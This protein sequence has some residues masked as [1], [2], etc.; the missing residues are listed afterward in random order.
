MA[1][2]FITPPMTFGDPSTALTG[3][4]RPAVIDNGAGF[5]VWYMK[6]GTMYHSTADAS[7]AINGGGAVAVTLTGGASWVSSAT[8]G[9]GDCPFVIKADDGKFY[10]WVADYAGTAIELYVATEAAG[11]WAYIR[12]VF[13][14]SSTVGDWDYGK[15]DEPMVIFDGAGY[16]LFY[17]GSNLDLSFTY[18]IGLANGNTAAI[19]T[20][21]TANP[22]NPVLIPTG[23]TFYDYRVFQPYVVK[24]GGQYYMWFGGS[25]IG[26]TAGPD[27]IGFATSTDLTSWN[28]A[29]NPIVGALDPVVEAAPS[30]VPVG[31]TWHV[32]YMKGADIAHATA[33][34]LTGATTGSF[35]VVFSSGGAPVYGTILG[36]EVQPSVDFGDV[37]L[38]SAT[39][40]KTLAVKNTG[41]VTEGFT[42][43]VDNT[44]AGGAVVEVSDLA[45]VT[46]GAVGNADVNINTLTA[47]MGQHSVVI[48]ITAHAE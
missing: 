44:N 42:F 38:G 21:Y 46:V 35:T 11:P 13:A 17:Q 47:T 41:N 4:G 40:A 37:M 23:G 19:D 27:A 32:W 36:V 15:I 1:S 12:D 5:D 8:T 45:R 29:P 3:A 7:G 14:K 48:T 22:V 20:E 10:M 39:N 6:S 25:S 28:L 33:S 43:S 24:T 30:V 9:L 26:Y 31:G 16:R 2:D 34:T 18:N